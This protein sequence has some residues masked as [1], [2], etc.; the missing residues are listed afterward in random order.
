MSATKRIMR[1]VTDVYL[2]A[3]GVRWLARLWCGHVVE[4]H[5]DQHTGVLRRCRE[6]ERQESDPH[7]R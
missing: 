5:A 7:A 2:S 6:C 1:R 3:G 4:S